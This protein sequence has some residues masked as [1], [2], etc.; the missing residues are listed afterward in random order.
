MEQAL[1]ACYSI[2]ENFTTDYK[3]MTTLGT[4]ICLLVKLAYHVPTMTSVAVK[5]VMNT[6]KYASLICRQVSIMKSLTHPN[7]IKVFHIVQVRETTYLLRQHTSGR[8]SRQHPGIWVSKEQGLKDVCP[9][10]TWDAV[11]S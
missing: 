10:T 8:A 2:E 6:T 4:G 7:I 11:L 1:E 9:D 5:L 3:V